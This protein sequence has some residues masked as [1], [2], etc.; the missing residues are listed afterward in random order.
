MSAAK[1]KGATV[2]DSPRQ[3]TTSALHTMPFENLIG[4]PLKAC[5]EAQEMA[6]DTTWRF[7]REV[8]FTSNDDEES[9]EVVMVSFLFQR[10]GRIQEISIPLLTLVPI[11]YISLETIDV[12]FQANLSASSNGELTAKFSNASL[13]G[14]SKYSIQ[15]LMDVKVHASSDSMPAGL[16][17]MLDLFSN[18]CIQIEEYEAPVVVTGVSLNKTSLAIAEGASETLVETIIPDNATNKSVSW[19][20]SDGTVATV[21]SFGKVTALKIGTAI[22]TVTTVDRKK[23]ATCAVTV[24]PVVVTGVSLNK[25]SL[26]IMEGLSETLAVT[27]S[28]NNATDKNVSWTTSNNAVVMVDNSGKVTA[29]KVGTADITVTTKD[30]KKTAICNITVNPIAVTGVSLNRTSLA[31][32]EGLSETLA[33]TVAPNN[34]TDKSVSWTTSNKTI[35]VVDNSGKVTAVKVGTA[36]ITVTTKDGNKV[37]VCKVTVNP[38]AVTGVSLSKASL[39]VTEGAS[40]ALKAIFKPKNASNKNVS[41]TTLDSA[42]ATAD[43]LGNI[44]AVKAG[45]TTITVTTKDGNKTASCDITADERVF[46]MMGVS[47]KRH[48]ITLLKGTSYESIVTFI[49]YNVLNKKVSWKTSNGTVATVDSSGKITA[50]SAGTATITIT[51]DDGKKTA[52]CSVTVISETVPVTGI[53]LNK[54]SLTL[55]GDANEKLIATVKPVDAT[56]KKVLWKITDGDSVAMVNQ[57]GNVFGLKPGTATVTATTADGNIM[58]TCSLTIK[59]MPVTGVLLNKDLLEIKKGADEVLIETVVPDNATIK[60]VSW[61]TSDGTIAKVDSFGNV[62]AIKAGSANITVTTDDGKKKATCKVVVK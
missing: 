37:A 62:T 3:V 60:G 22:I 44:T 39:T 52:S 26:A 43:G 20:S 18:S 34:A 50:V 8:G 27:V 13:T 1:K 24:K 49:P 32:M 5:V 29:L 12:S 38:V 54:D 53:S 41:W 15:H 40:E 30:G 7:I 36:D 46:Y 55:I 56:N 45:T 14:Q 19:K 47:L 42:V 16:A 57:I 10:Q 17:K 59:P 48:S 51:T 25:T 9:Q 6:T 4:G 23:T 35:A 31:I 58:K 11:P 2:D 21:D 33:V 61:E 28:P